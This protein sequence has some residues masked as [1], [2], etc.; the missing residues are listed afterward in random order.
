VAK[1]SSTFT[2]TK[3]DRRF[4]PPWIVDEQ[5]ACFVLRDRGGQA[6]AYV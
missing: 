6:W 4:P 2:L 3:S 5:D 1:S